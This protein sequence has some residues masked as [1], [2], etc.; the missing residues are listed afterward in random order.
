MEFI[1]FDERDVD[2]SKML[3]RVNGAHQEEIT[4]LAYDHH[5]SVVATGC[6]NGEIA[7]YDFEL[8][9]VEGLL[10]G[11]TGDI[12]DIKFLS[13]LPVLVSSSMDCTVCIWAIRPCPS[14]L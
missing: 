11:H 13:P 9:R 14:K 8:S 10:I 2:E 4:L 1:V 5:L 3:R 7:V 6:I 12:T